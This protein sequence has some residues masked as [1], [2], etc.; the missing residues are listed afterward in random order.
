[1]HQGYVW[2]GVLERFEDSVRLLSR[3]LPS[4]F[5]G[6]AVERAAREHAR[7]DSKYKPPAYRTPLRSTLQKIA[8]ENAND[9]TLY[10]L[11]VR[12]LDCRLAQCGLAV[13][14][15]TSVLSLGRRSPLQPAAAVPLNQAFG[16]KRN[17]AAAAILQ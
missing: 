12:L 2:V 5:G 7:P 14:S 16:A 11:A 9:I 3:L 4:F 15:A 10:R 8:A 17:G 1:M 6:I 13:A